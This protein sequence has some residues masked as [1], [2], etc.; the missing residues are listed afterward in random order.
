[1]V[2]EPIAGEGG[3]V[4]PAPGWLAGVA[5][6]CRA[7]GALFVADEIQS[8]FGRTGA[9]F[10]CEHEGVVPDLVTTAKSLGGGLPIGAVTGRAEIMDAVHVG[11]LGGTFG[12][13]PVSCAAALAAIDTIETDGLLGR[14]GAIGATM[15]GAL[16]SMA[17][18]HA[19][20]GEARGRGA[21]V[22]IELVEDDGVTPAAPATKALAAACHAQGLLVLTA[23]TY[24]N[25]L[26]L[27]PPLVI[28]EDLLVEGLGII[29]EALARL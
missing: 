21:M 12:G 23:G 29:D 5:A 8:G 1:M 16:T 6:W 18:T 20:V 4:V 7:N 22:A 2:V 27:L 19:V 14:A 26:R 24:G 25:V 13:N 15:L 28:P 10:A 3:F 17:A 9:W 11:G